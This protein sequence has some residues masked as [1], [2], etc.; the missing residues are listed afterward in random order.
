[1]RKLRLPLYEAEREWRICPSTKE[2]NI[3][4]YM[5]NGRAQL[6]RIME[7]RQ[8]QKHMDIENDKVSYYVIADLS[9]WAE[10]SPEK[11]QAGAF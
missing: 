9:T 1:M 8:L 10:N 6:E 2:N 11:E 4:S 3:G 7:A 5:L